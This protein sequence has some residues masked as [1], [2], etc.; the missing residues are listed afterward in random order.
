MK[1]I[2]CVSDKTYFGRCINTVHLYMQ[3]SSTVV[4]G[5]SLTK[6]NLILKIPV[7]GHFSLSAF[8]PSASTW[9]MKPEAF[10]SA[11]FCGNVYFSF[12]WAFIT[13]YSSLSC[14][15]LIGHLWIIVPTFCLPVSFFFLFQQTA[16]PSLILCGS[17]CNQLV[18]FSFKL[19]NTSPEN[20][21][22]WFGQKR[23]VG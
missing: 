5:G 14:Q 4:V 22:R 3:I 18:L 1:I 15:W 17:G 2:N 21:V 12:F 19:Q 23:N 16:L 7:A 11:T 8:L 6:T 20:A 13:H 9:G 10:K